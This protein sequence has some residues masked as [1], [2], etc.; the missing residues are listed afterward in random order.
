MKL[1]ELFTALG[2]ATGALV[3]WWA[4]REKRLATDGMGRIA[5][6]GFTVGILGAKLTELLVSGWPVKVPWALAFDPRVGGRALL[7]GVL[8]GW[9]GVEIAKRR[10]GIRRSTGDL[11]ALALP[12]GEAVGRIGCYFNGCCYGEPTSVPWAIYQ[13]D[14]YRHPTELYSAVAGLVIFA[15]LAWARKRTA[16]EGQLFW[17]Y[18]L[19]FGASRFVIEHFRWQSG[20]ILGLSAM[21]WLCLELSVSAGM[22]LIVKHRK[23]AGRSRAKMDARGDI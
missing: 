6:A 10:M 22:A 16:Y 15:L 1:G 19:L 5:I 9:L 8:F 13:H 17:I 3:F 18:L 7:G 2:Y 21:Q 23:M 4:A 20:Y 11:F 14:A 12:A